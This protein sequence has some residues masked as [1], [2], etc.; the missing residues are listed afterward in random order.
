MII[1]WFLGIIVLIVV[2]TVLL[3]IFKNW[4]SM[5][6][7]KNLITFLVIGGVALFTLFQFTA[8]SVTVRIITYSILIIISLFYG[9]FKK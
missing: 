2:V 1:L 6:N 4:K 9:S 5:M 3:N 7:Y 8:E